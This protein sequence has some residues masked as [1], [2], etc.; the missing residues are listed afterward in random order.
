LTAVANNIGNR[1]A[2]IL[3]V[4][5]D[6]AILE[7]L[8]TRLHIA[9]Y[10]TVTARDG[11]GALDRLKDTRPA[12]MLLDLS[13]P[14]VDGFE[15][16][17]ELSRRCDLPAPPVLVLTARNQAA[18]VQRAIMLGASDY[19]AKPFE[20]KMLLLRVARLLKPPRAPGSAGPMGDAGPQETFLL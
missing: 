7:L 13:M 10:S 15:V 12:A 18:D 11:R 6:P 2:R 5:D 20:T 17:S 8:V 19:M 16:L 14:I 9:G 1:N 3:V 4:D